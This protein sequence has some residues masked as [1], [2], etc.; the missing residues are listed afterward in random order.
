MGAK[1][2]PAHQ[3]AHLKKAATLAEAGASARRGTHPRRPAGAGRGGRV[4]LS[5]DRRDQGMA[6]SASSRVWSAWRQRRS[7]HEQRHRRAGHDRLHRAVRRPVRH[8]LGHHEQLHR[9]LESPDHQPCRRRARHRRSPA[10]DRA[11]PGPAIPAV[12][13]YNHFARA[14]AAHKALVADASARCCVWFPSQDRRSAG[15]PRHRVPPG[16]LRIVPYGPAP[17]YRRRRV[18]RKPRNQRHAVHRRH[19]GA[20][21]WLFTVAARAHPS[22]WPSTCP[23]P[24]PTAT[25]PKRCS[26]PSRLTSACSS[27]KTEAEAEALGARLD[28][29]PQGKKDTTIFF[30]ADKGVDYGDLM[31]VMGPT[32]DA[33]GCRR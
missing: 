24:P 25:R 6:R 7:R 33:A 3:I 11:G 12:V 4:R 21:R 10:G 16:Q 27:V 18:R 17:A 26:S 29:R 2:R 1:R 14:I 9:H 23:P 30:Q 8:C 20:A 19:A 22:T 15:P 5:A 31:S 28:A 32:C 13:I